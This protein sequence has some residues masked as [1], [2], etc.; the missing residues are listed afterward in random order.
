MPLKSIRFCTAA[1]TQ[2][3]NI[4]WR[5]PKRYPYRVIYEVI[6]AE[7]LVIVAAVLHAARQDSIWRGR[8]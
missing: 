7:R 2:Q 3:K 5:Y 1:G 6:E 4:R 8:V